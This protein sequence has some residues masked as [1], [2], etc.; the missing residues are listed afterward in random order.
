VLALSF[1]IQYCTAAL[2]YRELIAESTKEMDE[3]LKKLSD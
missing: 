3:K 2:L 1:S